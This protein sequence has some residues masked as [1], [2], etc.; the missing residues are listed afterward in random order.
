MTPKQ[1]SN[2]SNR[3]CWLLILIL[4]LGVILRVQHITDPLAEHHSWRQTQTAMIARNLH[5]E[6]MNLW[7]PR[8]DFI[9]NETDLLVLEFPLYN[10]IVALLYRI[11]GLHEIVGRLVSISFATG[12]AYFLYRFTRRFYGA[13]IALF[14]ILFFTLSPLSIFYGRAFMP[15]PL[16]L[17]TGIG[18]LLY[19]HMWIEDGGRK[20]FTLALLFSIVTFLTKFSM[21]HLLLPMVYLCWAKHGWEFVT[22]RSLY[23]FLALFLIPSA[24]WLLHASGSPNLNMSWLFSTPDLIRSSEFYT[25]MLKRLR[26]DVLTHVGF[27]LFLFGLFL[28]MR[29][30]S[31][32]L[33]DVWLASSLLFILVMG[34]G[35]YVHDYYQFPIIPIA[36]I[37]IGKAMGYLIKPQVLVEAGF[38]RHIGVVAAIGLLLAAGSESLRIVRPWYGQEIPGLYPFVDLVK[39]T[40]PAGEKVLI[41]SASRDFAPWDPRIMYAV[42][43]K[44][45]NVPPVQLFGEIQRLRPRNVGYLVVYPLEG[46]QSN[47]LNQLITR[48]GLLAV[49]NSGQTGAVFDLTSSQSDIKTRPLIQEDFQRAET[50]KSEWENWGDGFSITASRHSDANRA[51]ELRASRASGF[52]LLQHQRIEVHPGALYVARVKVRAEQLLGPGVGIYMSTYRTA[53][54]WKQLSSGHSIIPPGRGWQET[55]IVFSPPDGAHFLLVGLGGRD[56]DGVAQFD[57]FELREAEAA[58]R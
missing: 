34:T 54:D 6:G 52:H 31:E 11:F 21:A 30:K 14:T 29:K 23:L 51:L 58:A 46:L 10:A 47:L 3:E 32:Y 38:R 1:D 15:E 43:H 44:G 39:R 5:R 50:V 20:N 7:S 48:Y 42:D 2:K 56:L 26:T 24:I 33:F 25:R 13:S 49:Q 28:G 19:F 12:A 35:N 27:G 57:N 17:F 53:E 4:A 55:S 40:I 9:F 36:S 37:Y 18:A 22:R 41:S 16:M 8:V 45:W